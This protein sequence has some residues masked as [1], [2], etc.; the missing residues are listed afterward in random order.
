MVEPQAVTVG[1][2]SRRCMR[3]NLTGPVESTR[4]RAEGSYTTPHSRLPQPVTAPQ[5]IPL[6]NPAT[7]FAPILRAT[8]D[9][10]TR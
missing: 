3:P 1:G 2:N 5:V 10:R 4:V 9:T 6:H 7:R 8:E